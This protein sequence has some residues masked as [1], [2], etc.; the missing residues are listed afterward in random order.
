MKCRPND[1]IKVQAIPL[2]AQAT[3]QATAQAKPKAKAGPNVRNVA[4]HGTHKR[5]PTFELLARTQ[6]L[7]HD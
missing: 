2:G 3:A 4:N 1:T 6:L 5:K 7:T